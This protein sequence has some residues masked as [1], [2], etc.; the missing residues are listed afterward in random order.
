MNIQFS[1][2]SPSS[3]EKRL[4]ALSCLSFYL[5]LIVVQGKCKRVDFGRSSYMEF[6][7]KF[8]YTFQFWLKYDKRNRHFVWGSSYFVITPQR[9]WF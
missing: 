4:L 5:C 9:Y 1:A 6:L 3:S 2:P 7:P 8:V